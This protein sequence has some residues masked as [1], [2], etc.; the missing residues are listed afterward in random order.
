MRTAVS[1][2]ALCLA[3]VVVVVAALFAFG[4][5]S[6]YGAAPNGGGFREAISG[7]VGSLP[8]AVVV[9]LLLAVGTRR[10]S[11]RRRLLVALAGALVAVL[12]VAGGMA[13]GHHALQRRCEDLGPQHS[14]ACPTATLG[15]D[16]HAP[17]RQPTA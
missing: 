15:P 9:A 5:T 10:T 12:A 13:L 6:E 3:A 17:G 7:V 14:A 2:V 8:A 4:L 11:R 16:F 1:V